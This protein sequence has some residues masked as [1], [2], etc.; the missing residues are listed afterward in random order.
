M[1]NEYDWKHV[2]FT[3]TVPQVRIG[4]IGV[5]DALKAAWTGENR[6][7]A[8]SAYTVEFWVK[9][10]DAGIQSNNPDVKEKQTYINGLLFKEINE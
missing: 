6:P 3:Y 2:A 9:P 10:N 5:W 1:S 4:W 7:Q 8:T